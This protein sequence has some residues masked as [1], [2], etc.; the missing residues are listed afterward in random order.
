M[1]MSFAR[2]RVIRGQLNSLDSRV[3]RELANVAPLRCHSF[4][5]SVPCACRHVARCCFAARIPPHRLMKSFA[6]PGLVLLLT[7][8]PAPG[9]AAEMPVWA[10]RSPKEEVVREAIPPPA[11]KRFEHLAWPKAV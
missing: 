10:G 6:I 8:A 1:E 7:L 3:G 4:R 5:L 2:I 9:R 11:N